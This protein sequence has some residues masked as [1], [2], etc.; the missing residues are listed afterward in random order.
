MMKYNLKCLFKFYEMKLDVTSGFTH[1]WTLLSV[2]PVPFRG[3]S[4]S[5]FYNGLILDIK[6]PNVIYTKSDS[7]NLKF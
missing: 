2:G 3:D 6:I 4:Y 5:L 1:Y 7:L